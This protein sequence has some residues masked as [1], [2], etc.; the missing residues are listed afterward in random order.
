MTSSSE[1]FAKLLEI[2]NAAD[3]FKKSTVRSGA[4]AL[5]GEA[6]DFVLR[7]GSLVILARLLLPEHFG[8]ISMVTAIT[9]VG[10]RFKDLGLMSATIQS[11]T[12]N[13]KQSSTL[14]W[15]NAAIGAAIMLVISALA[16][17]IARFYRDSRLAY[18]TLAIA[19]TFLWSGA[20]NQHHALLRRSMRYRAIAVIQ[21]TASAGSIAVAIVM[22][23]QGSGYWALVAREVTRS[24][25]LSIGAW[26]CFPW[27]PGV[28][29]KGTGVRHMLRFG[30]DITAVNVLHL[31]TQSLDQILIGKVFGAHPLGLYRQ[32]Y[33]LALAPLNQISYPIRVVAES[34]L[35]RL[36]DDAPRYRN[37]YRNILKATSLATVPVGLFMA[38]YA[39]EIVAVALGRDWLAAA[40]V[41]RILGLA[42]CLRPAAETAGAVMVS[43]GLSR[44]FFRLGLL[45]ATAFTILVLAGLPFGLEGVASAHLL[46]LWLLLV[47]KLYWSF[48]ATPVRVRDFFASVAKP[49]AA[50]LVMSVSLILLK[51]SGFPGETRTS[52]ALGTVVGPAVFLA[53]LVCL[54]GGRTD[55]TNLIR[56]L[57]ATV[58]K[59]RDKTLPPP[60]KEG[61]KPQVPDKIIISE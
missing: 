41:F 36:Q 38:V 13:H 56:E 26:L 59:R 39:E 57:A 14:F 12:L 47:P 55:L 52:L 11:P 15:V 18:I 2:P 61:S 43:R 58:T 8:L 25:F 16:Y 10:E 46:A 5:M 35:S 37:Y 9:A 1:R 22:A 28:P 17:P 49:A 50:S 44:R 6:V 33:Q 34:A 60:S 7:L 30:V 29:S 32:G 54:P 21:L 42:S 24:A 3:D 31:L 40:P 19:S 53:T 51:T 48:Q 20:A 23:V 45:S 27:I 4:Y